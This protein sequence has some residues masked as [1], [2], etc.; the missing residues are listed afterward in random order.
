VEIL[1]PQYSTRCFR[2][3]S[4][5]QNPCPARLSKATRQCTAS[6]QKFPLHQIFVIDHSFIP[7]YIHFT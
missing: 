3:I 1:A 5:N 4:I 6:S 2:S 7:E